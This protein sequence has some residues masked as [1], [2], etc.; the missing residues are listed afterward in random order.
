M[1][2]YSASGRSRVLEFRCFVR[3]DLLIALA[4]LGQDRSRYCMGV[5][6]RTARRNALAIPGRFITA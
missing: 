6:A 3:T 4:E 5:G 2:Q 1:T